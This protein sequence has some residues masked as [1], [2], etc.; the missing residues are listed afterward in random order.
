[1]TG[2]SKHDP[3]KRLSD[4]ER[5]TTG[6]DGRGSEG[7]ARDEPTPIIP[8][9]D[10][11]PEPDWFR[12]ATQ[13]DDAEGKPDHVWTY[14]DVHGRR[15]FLVARWDLPQR[16][17]EDKP[18]KIIRPV[19]FCI[20]PDGRED[21]ALKAMPAL[22]PLYR[23]LE[24]LKV[25]E[26]GLVI[27]V[28]GEKCADAVVK[29]WSIPTVTWSGGAEAWQKTDWR[30]LAGRKVLLIPDA[31]D[32][33]RKVMQELAGHL[34]GLGCN[35]SWVL[36]DG[37]TGEDVVDWFAAAGPEVTR[38]RVKAARQDYVPPADSTTSSSKEPGGSDPENDAEDGWLTE[39]VERLKTDPGAIYESAI[40]T[41]L[42]ELHEVDRRAWTN[43]R[44]RVKRECRGQLRIRDLDRLVERG[45]ADGLPGRPVEYDDPEPW[46]DPVD[47]AELLDAFSEIIL[48]Y[49]HLPEGGAEAAA[50]WALFTW[51]FDAFGVCPNLLVTAPERESG[52]TRLTS[53]LSWMVRRP[54]PVSA[55]S[56]AAI[57]RGIERNGPT[58]LFDEA[59]SLFREKGEAAEDMKQ[60]LR[61]SF[62]RRFAKVLKCIGERNEER[63]F[64]TF[65]PKMANGRDLAN[66]DDMLT[67][68]SVVI[69]M[70]RATK[71]FPELRD[72]Q[73]IVGED[74]RRMAVRWAED[75]VGDLEDADPDMGDLIHRGAQVWRSLFAVA[76]AA[77]GDWPKRTRDA[78]RQLMESASKVS[79]GDTLGVELLA[80]CR[81][82]F[83]DRG[84]PEQIKSSDL[85]QYLEEL[86]DRPWK[87]I[88]KGDKPLTAQRR[89]RMLQKYG[90][91]SEP[92]RFGNEHGQVRGYRREPFENQW[93][94][95]LSQDEGES[96]P[97][98]ATTDRNG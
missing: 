65:C 10:D 60:M 21:W 6:K 66:I 84:N 72:D 53:V 97:H 27:V 58:L 1:M 78:A 11:A 67:S 24:L 15:T 3:F 92:L 71:R 49:V 77:G 39:L 51:V 52:K 50:V 8:I 48:E 63:E 83:K 79:L 80:D 34:H 44:A 28:E 31:D 13:L 98:T 35:V 19:T 94:A 36:L 54:L 32:A 5:A 90:I 55:A 7:R 47:G 22:R 86:P 93:R 76:D 85:D 95:Y 45:S 18:G 9:P 96:D 57:V 68:R 38:K 61:A 30:P 16:E 17:G 12:I 56:V 74:P 69:P 64:S 88:M 82:F 40:T 89:G 2:S 81:Q 75:C 23:L 59:Q 26:N 20:L 42:R 14:Y 46:P 73:D 4:E 62:T 33:G 43:F 25:P 87:S 29:E 70:T 41:R 37:D 91:K